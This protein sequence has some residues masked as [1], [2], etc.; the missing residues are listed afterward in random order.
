MIQILSMQMTSFLHFFLE[1]QNV[2]DPCY[3]FCADLITRK[4][5]LIN[6]INSFWCLCMKEFLKYLLPIMGNLLIYLKYLIIFSY[7]NK[8]R[9]SDWNIYILQ[10][11]NIGLKY[12]R[13]VLRHCLMLLY[14]MGCKKLATAVR[15]PASRGSKW[16]FLVVWK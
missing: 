14:G 2:D 3:I 10:M 16:I 1:C 7:F 13:K 12:W 15:W 9:I 6:S 4:T 11:L 8:L 5:I